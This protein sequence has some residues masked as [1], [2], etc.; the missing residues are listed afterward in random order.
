MKKTASLAVAAVALLSWACS[1]GTD[2]GSEPAVSLSFSTRTPGAQPAPGFFASVVAAD[3]L[4]DG[5]NELIIT[6]AEVV[7]REVELERVE[8]TDCDV[9]PEP[10][11]CEE[12]EAG[13]LLLDV[14]LNGA[15]R[16]Q[17]SIP[18]PPGLYDELEF[19]IHK[20]SN[21][22]PED[23]AFRAAH[24][25]MVGKSIRVQGFFND[26]P[27]TFESDL[28]VE[29]EFEL[30]PPLVVEATTSSTNVTVR[31]DIA[32]WFR[33]AV[34]QLVNPHDG[35][36]GGPHENLIKENIKQSIEAFEDKDGD[37]DDSDE[38]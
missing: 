11:G 26:Q 6:K 5:Q 14:P 1:D 35:N 30:S 19:D 7:L 24:P 4:T 22:D 20:V 2:P 18:V 27:F 28:D 8:V 9:E 10:E 23:A 12:F 37:G 15:T 3:T 25:D 21:D 36:K 29:Q 17:V 33:D 13:P 32:Q 34:G 38:G 16:Q 31:L